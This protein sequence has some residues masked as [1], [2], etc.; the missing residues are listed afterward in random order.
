[1]RR[2]IGP[3]ADDTGPAGRSLAATSTRRAPSTC[4]GPKP[5]REPHAAGSRAG[6]DRG[7]QGAGIVWSQPTRR[8]LATLPGN[9]GGLSARPSILGA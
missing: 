1:M 2:E 5:Q 3:A 4:K 7:L 8:C 9:V 6:R